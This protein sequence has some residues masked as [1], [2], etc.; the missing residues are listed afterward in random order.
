MLH[1]LIGPALDATLP[2]MASFFCRTLLTF[3]AI[4]ASIHS[5]SY[6]TGVAEGSR[7]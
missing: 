5:F 2:M 4:I 3:K 7:G 6:G 1:V